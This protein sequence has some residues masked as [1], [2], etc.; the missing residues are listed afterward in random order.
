MTT[1]TGVKTLH[2]WEFPQNPDGIFNPTN[3]RVP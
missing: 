3:R 2:A 1:I